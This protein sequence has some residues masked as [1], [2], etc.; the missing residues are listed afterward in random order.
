MFSKRVKCIFI[1]YIFVFLDVLGLSRMS[2]YFIMSNQNILKRLKQ[3]FSQKDDYDVEHTA[4]TKRKTNSLGKNVRLR[5]YVKVHSAQDS[6]SDTETSTSTSTRTGY[7]VRVR[8]RVKSTN[9]SPAAARRTKSLVVA[10]PK[11]PNKSIV[12]T[13]TTKLIQPPAYACCVN[14]VKIIDNC[15]GRTEHNIIYHQH[16]PIVGVSNAGDLAAAA[17]TEQTVVDIGDSALVCHSATTPRFKA[18]SSHCKRCCTCSKQKQLQTLPSRSKRQWQTVAE[19]KCIECE[20]EKEKAKKEL[21]QK[22]KDFSLGEFKS[23]QQSSASA[24]HLVCTC[25]LNDIQDNMK[26]RA[27][28]KA[29]SVDNSLCS[30]G[31]D[32]SE[33]KSIQDTEP[34][35]SENTKAAKQAL[36]HKDETAAML[37]DEPS[38]ICATLPSKSAIAR[39]DHS[40]DFVAIENSIASS[41]IGDKSNVTENIK[42][43]SFSDDDSRWLGNGSS[44]YCTQSDDCTDTASSIISSS[45]SQRSTATCSSVHGMSEQNVRICESY[46]KG[47]AK[48]ANCVDGLIDQNSPQP[49]TSLNFKDGME[50]DIIEKDTTPPPIPQ[51]NYRTNSFYKQQQLEL[52]SIPTNKDDEDS[53][54]SVEMLV[55]ISTDQKEVQAKVS[56]PLLTRRS[57]WPAPPPPLDIALFDEIDSTESSTDEP[58]KEQVSGDEP[59]H[60]TMEEVWLDAQ[61]H[62]IPLQKPVQCDRTYSTPE[63]N[64]DPAP[65]CVR[66]SSV[67]DSVTTP[68]HNRIEREQKLFVDLSTKCAET[69][70]TQVCGASGDLPYNHPSSSMCDMTTNVC[71][72]LCMVDGP[73]N[74]TA[75]HN[76]HTMPAGMSSTGA[77]NVSVSGGD[78]PPMLPPKRRGRTIMAHGGASGCD[79]MPAS[80][81]TPGLLTDNADTLTQTTRDLLM[82][83]DSNQLGDTGMWSFSYLHN[84]VF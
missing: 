13:A 63:Q 45:E 79:D 26:N 78:V 12:A 73:V 10:S 24:E 30:G 41:L 60:M 34:S 36:L 80:N 40:K 82:L 16:H 9:S 68:P 5:G 55:D 4:L 27:L 17:I 81:V 47:L 25:G 50:S 11:P 64:P 84:T 49:P 69:N 54:N 18:S 2:N 38:Y 28:E 44:G 43:S 83:D 57:E 23:K 22:Q 75:N 77:G 65:D 35:T 61:S 53:T 66:S 15:C 6:L 39:R 74:V 32:D 3:R 56:P 59:I 42:D 62:G 72:G 33:G 29:N 46:V 14:R 37:L 58:V 8:G 1:V 19:E 76:Y 70:E 71:G 7:H 21:F 48:E 52:L 31:I 51:R 67:P 20:K